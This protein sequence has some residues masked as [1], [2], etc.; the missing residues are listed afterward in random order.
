MGIKTVK[1]ITRHIRRKAESVAER[2]L[3]RGSSQGKSEMP[4]VV[5]MVEEQKPTGAKGH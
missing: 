4:I 2:G 3:K 5:K 1:G